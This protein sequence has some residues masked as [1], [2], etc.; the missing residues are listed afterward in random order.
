[1]S[2]P[3]DLKWRSKLDQ[4]FKALSASNASEPTKRKPCRKSFATNAAFWVIVI[5]TILA[6]GTQ[7]SYFRAVFQSMFW[8]RQ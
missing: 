7:A 5:P 3:E 4:R 2:Q 6:L 1:M 8:D